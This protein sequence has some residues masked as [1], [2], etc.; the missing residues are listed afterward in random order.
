MGKRTKEQGQL[1]KRDPAFSPAWGAEMSSKI[2]T[3][4][5]GMMLRSDSPMT[6]NATPISEVLKP[7]P[8]LKCNRKKTR[9]RRATKADGEEQ[10][11]LP[12]C[13]GQF[14]TEV[15]K[16]IFRCTDALCQQKGFVQKASLLSHLTLIISMGFF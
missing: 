15:L 3:A 4:R 16:S 11:I 9:S 1:D 8:E 2:Q 13:T 5:A 14:C 10:F 6:S 7:L 12:L